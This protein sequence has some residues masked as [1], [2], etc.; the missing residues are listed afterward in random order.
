MEV[1]KSA[2]FA[3]MLIFI[4]TRFES[5]GS[6]WLSWRSY[7]HSSSSCSW[8]QSI[9]SASKAFA[10]PYSTLHD[11]VTGKLLKHYY[12][13]NVKTTLK[14]ERICAGWPTVL[15]TSE[16]S[17]V[18]IKSCMQE[19][20]FGLKREIVANV[21][22]SYLKDQVHPLTVYIPGAHWWHGFL[23]RW[24]K[25]SE[26]KPQHLSAKRACSNC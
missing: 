24:P 26:W 25:L 2:G 21:I 15:T 7:C 17:E 18:V 19:L 3:R 12:H 10:V 23:K 4:H 22:R 1:T 5:N 6:K 14:T 8:G 13:F 20:G 16:A 9:R 11:Y